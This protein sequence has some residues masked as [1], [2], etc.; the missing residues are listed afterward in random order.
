MA[1]ACGQVESS[2]G[3]IADR[4]SPSLKW[5][6]FILWGA[7]AW[8]LYAL[9][10]LA[11]HVAG[12]RE[13]WFSSGLSTCVERIQAK[14]TN[15]QSVNHQKKKKTISSSDQSRCSTDA[16]RREVWIEFEGLT[17][18]LTLS[19]PPLSIGPRARV[20]VSECCCWER[21]L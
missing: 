7:M 18:Q 2:R 14:Y 10:R 20:R 17:R 1:F 21:V 4:N 15:S 11:M 13:S 5:Y 16:V 12:I 8:G 6:W 19:L 3:A 9:Q